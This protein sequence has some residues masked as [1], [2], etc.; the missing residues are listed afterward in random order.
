MYRNIL[1]LLAIFYPGSVFGIRHL[2]SDSVLHI[3]IFCGDWFFF[4]VTVCILFLTPDFSRMIK[5]TIIVLVN[6]PPLE[7]ILIHI[8][9]VTPSQT[10]LQD[11]SWGRPR[12]SP[13]PVDEG[14]VEGSVAL[15]QSFF[16]SLRALVIQCNYYSTNAAYS[17]GE[18]SVTLL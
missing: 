7:P 12:F 17:F 15:G 4:H 9:S 8:S 14:F 6:R 13:R 18:L 10:T 1:F 5:M 16:F 3:L 2:D 11:L